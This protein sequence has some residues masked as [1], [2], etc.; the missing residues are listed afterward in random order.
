MKNRQTNDW[1]SHH[2]FNDN[3]NSTTTTTTNGSAA[4][5]DQPPMSPT[6]RPAGTGTPSKS[7]ESEQWYRYDAATT[8]GV[9]G[10]RNSTSETLRIHESQRTRSG[11]QDWYKHGADDRDLVDV[12]VQ[13]PK[14]RS[15]KRVG[16]DGR[17]TAAATASGASSD[18][19]DWYRY[20]HD[21][22]DA[23][24]S[25]LSTPVRRQGNVNNRESTESPWNLTVGGGGGDMVDNGTTAAAG[26]PVSP[27]TTKLSGV[28]AEANYRRDKVGS[29]ADWYTHH[30]GPPTSSDPVADRSA[31]GLPSRGFR[32][33]GKDGQRIADKLSVESDAWFDHDANRNYTAPL[34]AV[35]GSSPLTREMIERAKGGEMRQIFQ[36]EQNLHVA[37]TAPPESE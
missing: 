13:R 30:D 1:F 5:A 36:M 7:Q 25:E 15:T 26:P 9:A 19:N 21:E 32:V 6:R 23:A 16:P 27:R 11:G 34:P 22:P 37:W 8:D 10:P 3:N 31:T 18:P 24:T 12:G 29:S 28:E 35:K 14:V 4:H 20:D 33:G 17:S 2:D